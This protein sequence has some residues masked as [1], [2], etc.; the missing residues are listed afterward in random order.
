M[1]DRVYNFSAGPSQLPLPVLK[2]AQQDLLNYPGA[3]TSVLE[4]SHRSKAFE[5]IIEGA[6]S[7][8]RRLM[9]IPDDYA[10]LFLQGGATLQFSMT[11][12]NLAKQGDT[13]AF[14]RSGLFA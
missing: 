8:L 10:V 13:M 14:I 1:Q 6:E 7:R 3:G 9:D 11:A 12:M 5:S 2:E 4:M